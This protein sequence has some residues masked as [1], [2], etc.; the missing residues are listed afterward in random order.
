MHNDGDEEDKK[1]QCGVAKRFQLSFSLLSHIVEDPINVVISF[2]SLPLS[3]KVAIIK[4]P[5]FSDCAFL[6]LS[7]FISIVDSDTTATTGA[8]SAVGCCEKEMERKSSQISASLPVRILSFVLLSVQLKWGV[9]AQMVPPW[10]DGFVYGD[11]AEFNP[12]NILIEAFFD[13]VCP[14]TRDA[15]PSLKQALDFYG[16]RL[17]LIVHPFPLPY[18]DNA[19]VTSWALHI[20]NGLNS[21]ATYSLWES[22]FKH[23]E[24]FYNEA[25]INMS[26]PEV[27]DKISDFIAKSLGHSYYSAVKTGF[28]DVNTELKTLVSFKVSWEILIFSINNCLS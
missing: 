8:C 3:T 1:G 2:N 17:S 11:T 7:L 18:H 14:D 19:F 16:S 9:Q 13:P 25:T 5:A 6:S 12:E 15:W 28:N 26:R 4:P 21:S 22:F 24:K 10:F 20:V 27:V 23:Q